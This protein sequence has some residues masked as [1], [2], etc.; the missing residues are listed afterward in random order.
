MSDEL[1]VLRVELAAQRR[2]VYFLWAALAVIGC[3]ALLSRGR[4]DP[5]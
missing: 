1:H 4:L 3:L 5:L 2:Q